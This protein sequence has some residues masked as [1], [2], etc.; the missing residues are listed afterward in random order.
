MSE[1]I[2]INLRGSTAFDSNKILV[3]RK[4]TFE[5]I[6]LNLIMNAKFNNKHAQTLLK[7]K[8][9]P[10]II[11]KFRSTEEPLNKKI[12]YICDIF[13]AGIT[14]EFEKDFNINIPLSI[15]KCIRK[16]FELGVADFYE[17]VIAGDLSSSD[18]WLDLPYLI[19]RGHSQYWFIIDN[20]QF[21]IKIKE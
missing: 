21:V 19:W 4:E 6:Q 5:S 12:Q 8:Y 15:T 14:R 17:K 20:K 18:G 1:F 10:E 11:Q 7:A 3:E 16:Y 9:K 13:F 2:Q